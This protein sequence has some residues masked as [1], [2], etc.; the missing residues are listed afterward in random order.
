M[1]KK[2]IAAA[3]S[4]VVVAPASQ[5]QQSDAVVVYGRI[6]QGIWIND[7]QNA[8]GNT[9]VDQNSVS[10]RFGIKYNKEI[11]NGLTAHGRYEFFTNPDREQGTT[12]RGGVNDIR[13]GTV[14]VSG[15]FGRVDVGNQWSAYFNTVGTMMSPTYSI[16]YFIYSSIGGGP[17][18]A[19]N[20]I[21]YSNS[22]GPL[23]VELDV[24]LND[25]AEPTA[26][27]EKINGGAGTG[28]AI[29]ATWSITDAFSIAAAYDSEDGVAP[30][31]DDTER[32]AIS[33]KF[34]F[35]D[36]FIMAG[37]Q[38]L[39]SNPNKGGVDVDSGTLYGGGTLGK[40]TFL[41]GVSTA[42]LNT[43]GQSDPESVVWAY[44]YNMGGGIKLYYEATSVDEK[45]AGQAADGTI[46]I[47]GMRVD[48]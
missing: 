42:D 3:V 7:A 31:S 34:S 16:G 38:N 11:G 22:F 39:D 48:F 27:T 23:Y 45:G 5:A 8:L 4:A 9:L 21:K 17:F 13:I 33:G 46:H 15:S 41:L 30:G 14:G 18:R 29:A 47:L 28:G 25:S 35:G 1:N 20:T 10:S 6:N 26:I 44:Y 24:R 43:A 2:L 32:T 12:N 36:Y 40:S 37:F 19:S